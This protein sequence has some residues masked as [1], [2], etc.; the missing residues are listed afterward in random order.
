MNI[1]NTLDFATVAFSLITN[2][3]GLHMCLID[4]E[5]AINFDN[6]WANVEDTAGI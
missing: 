3:T 5:S 4:F 1:Q 6:P 2:T